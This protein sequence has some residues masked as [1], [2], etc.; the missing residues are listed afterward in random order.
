MKRHFYLAGL[1][2]MLFFVGGAHTNAATITTDASCTLDLAIQ[3]VNT[4]TPVVGCDNGEVDL[5]NG[6]GTNDE[7][8]IG[9][10]ET[11]STAANTC[12]TANDAILKPITAD[13]IITGDNKTLT[14]GALPT[15]DFRLGCIDAGVSVTFRGGA[16]GPLTIADFY[17]TN[18]GAVLTVDNASAQVFL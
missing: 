16:S 3:S 9:I 17:H 5:T 6:W 11:Y 2:A 12:D 15:K 10:N 14:G 4:A 7:I 1:C 13:V 8:I 18:A